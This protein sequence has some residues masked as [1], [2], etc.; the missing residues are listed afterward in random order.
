MYVNPII[1]IK[2]CNKNLQKYYAYLLWVS[3]RGPT[4]RFTGLCYFLLCVFIG[5]L[6]L[7][8]SYCLF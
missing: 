2:L 5:E 3:K 8:L 6:S 4:R 1:I 7:Y